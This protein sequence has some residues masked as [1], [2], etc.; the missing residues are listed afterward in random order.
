L[1]FASVVSAVISAEAKENT[2]AQ[3]S[4]AIMIPVSRFIFLNLIHLSLIDICPL[5][6]KLPLISIAKT[7]PEN[8][9]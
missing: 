8:N 3:Q 4:T 5:R 1:P 9:L 6:A 2:S 7:P